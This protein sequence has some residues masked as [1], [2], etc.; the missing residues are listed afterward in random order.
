[1]A[2]D[3]LAYLQSKSLRP[4]RA[5]GV[6][7]HL[8]CMFCG[9]DDSERGRLY[10]NVDPYAT[11]TGLFHCFLCDESG[12]IV[13]LKKFYGDYERPVE[14]HDDYIRLAI[15]KTAADY[16]RDM[17]ESEN[18]DV[19]NWLRGPERMLE[20]ETVVDANL[21]YAPPDTQDALYR[22]LRSLNFKTADIMATG[23]VIDSNGRLTDALTG[24][25]TIPYYVAGNCVT[26]RGRRWPMEPDEK[27]KYKTLA[28]QAAR[29]YHSEACWGVTEVMI[30]EGELDA[31]V[32]G[33]MGFNAIGIP[34]ANVWQP[35]W[36]VYLEG[37]RRVW[38]AFDPDEA[39]DKGAEKLIERLGPKA[40]RLRL[41]SDVTE[42]VSH[43]H[44]ADE[45]TQIMAEMGRSPLL[46]SVDQA[47]DE[48]TEL[49]AAKGVKLDCSSLDRYIDP[50]LMPGQ[51]V[52]ILAGTGVGKTIWI[53][54][55]L[56][57][58]ASHP[59]QAGLKMLF[60]SLEQT[61][62]EWWERAR[63][64]WRF[65]NLNGTDQQCAN[66]WR[67]RLQLVD[68]NRLSTHELEAVLD[69]FEYEM[70]QKPDVVCLDYLGY[71]ARSF[72]GERYQQVGD[73]V[74][75]LKAVAK[76]RRIPFLAPHQVSRG[77]T[78]GEEPDIS[79]ARDAGSVEET[80]DILLS[81]WRPDLQKGKRD[82]EVDGKVL[83]RVKKSRAGN[84][85]KVQEFVFC[86]FSLALVP[87][88][89]PRYS[90]AHLMAKAE[91]RWDHD[92]TVASW[93]QA[94]QRHRGEG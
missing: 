86:P 71:F 68:K 61:R 11:I 57:R 13:K 3:V 26:I 43:G 22:F 27:Q 80:A 4:R 24:M 17:L 5:S 39:G 54:N 21:G 73:A 60:V 32:L 33:Q 78:Y 12:S 72:K 28:G 51:L 62:A 36:D 29:V 53:E 7:V 58:I 94:V 93:E 66:F 74:M 81:M 45:L 69:D 38:V 16:Y 70:G 55:M 92:R 42:W 46:I 18:R 20:L 65:Y 37:M 44:G 47:I 83:M 6:E 19:R 8:P 85:G 90:R 14:E 31:L 34:G 30:T 79:A 75:E 52:I 41:P 49:Q 77:T 35:G 63:R 84:V 9:E 15:L 56:Q 64:I 76:E 82:E 1:M 50:G 91:L 88:H 40:R 48:H 23:L 89:D 59:D 10:V 67:A 25:V 2:E 87:T